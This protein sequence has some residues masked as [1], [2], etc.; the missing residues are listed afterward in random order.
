MRVQPVSGPHAIS[1]VNT[2]NNSNSRSAAIAAFEKA[3]TPPQQ[4]QENPVLNPNKVSPE[5]L[6]AVNTPRQ[7]L[8]DNSSETPNS[9][10]NSTISEPQEET[11][12]PP[13]DTPESRRW[14]QLARTERQLRAKALQQEA[15]IKA[16]EAAIQA[17]EDAIAAKDKEYS[18]GYYRKDSIKQDPLQAL[19]D[20][21]V[22]YDE[23]TQQLLNQQPT[24]PRILNTIN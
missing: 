17:R 16:R 21:G 7:E 15:A 22:S 1:P 2:T 18:T 3:S 13:K 4:A 19:A 10:D 23:L 9:S 12:A 8:T 20:A 24:D 6:S 5:E 11:Q 14:A